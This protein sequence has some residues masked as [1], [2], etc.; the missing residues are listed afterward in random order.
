MEK[1]LI[2]G[3]TGFLGM[4][5]TP[6]LT[7]LGYSVFTHGNQNKADFNVDITSEIETQNLLTTLNPDVIIN[8]IGKTSVEGCESDINSAYLLNVKSVQNIVSAINKSKSNKFFIHISTDHI[9]D[10]ELISNESDIKIRNNYAMTKYAGE[11][12]INIEN[13]CVLRTNFVGKCSVPFKESLSDW[14]IKNCTEK[15]QVNVLDDVYFSPLSVTSLCEYLN[16]IIIKR[17][18]GTFNIGSKNGLSKADFDFKFAKL[19]KLDT[20]NMKRIELADAF[21][22]KASRP[23]NM[24][25]DVAKIESTL[26]RKMPSLV[27]EIERIAVEY[28]SFK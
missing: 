25:M 8:L 27:D 10:A 2:L 24:M 14:V 12:A 5:L 23:R 21:F 18:Q 13:S 20:H 16:L 28:N 7:K 15:S 17:T 4:R 6:F 22:F 11:L 9:Y 26:G 1:I 3:A 19:M